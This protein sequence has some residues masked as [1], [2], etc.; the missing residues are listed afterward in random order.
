MDPFTVV[1][2]EHQRWTEVVVFVKGRPLAALELKN[3]SAELATLS[4]VFHQLETYER[5]IPSLC[6]TNAAHGRAEGGHVDRRR[7]R[8]SPIRNPVSNEEHF[9]RDVPPWVSPLRGCRPS[10]A[11]RMI[12]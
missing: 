10:V 2:G 5:Q 9:K 6:R 12:A 8:G 11:L 1:E 3:P 4:T 7:T